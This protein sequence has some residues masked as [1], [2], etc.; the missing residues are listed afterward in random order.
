MI[1]L[2]FTLVKD[3]G[4]GLTRSIRLSDLETIFN[5]RL[6][7]GFWWHFANT[8][9]H[10]TSSNGQDARVAITPADMKGEKMQHERRVNLCE[11][12]EQIR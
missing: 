8:G 2:V 11:A 1:V 12:T 10:T 5:Q 4:F 6:E 3:F 9:L 7:P